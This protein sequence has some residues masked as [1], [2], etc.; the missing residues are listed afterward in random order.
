[1]LDSR[2]YR[3]IMYRDGDALRQA[4]PES[5]TRQLTVGEYV[6]T[7]RRE[8]RG[9]RDIVKVYENGRFL[10]SESVPAE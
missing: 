10:F 8:L 5:V 3:A 4:V 2:L 6:Y 1:M 7:I 9:W